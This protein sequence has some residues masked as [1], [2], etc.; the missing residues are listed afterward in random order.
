MLYGQAI[1]IIIKDWFNRQIK[2]PPVRLGVAGW[3][4]HEKKK[5]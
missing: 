1:Y 4:K 5:R 2:V 3:N